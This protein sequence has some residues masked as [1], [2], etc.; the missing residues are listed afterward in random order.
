MSLQCEAF[1]Q[2]LDTVAALDIIGV[3]GLTQLVQAGPWKDVH[4]QRLVMAFSTGLVSAR[5]Q[6]KPAKRDSQEI[7]AFQ[8]WAVQSEADVL[9]THGINFQVKVNTAVQM[10][11]RMGL[12]LPSEDSKAHIMCV[13]LAACPEHLRTQNATS[14]REDYL[15]L[16]GSIRSSFKNTRNP[17]PQGFIVQWPDTPDGLPASQREI[18]FGDQPYVAIC[19]AAEVTGA[20]EYLAMRGNSSKLKQQMQPSAGT[21]GPMNNPMMMMFQQMQQTMQHCMMAAGGSHGG[22]N[23]DDIN[24]S[25][26]QH[27]NRPKQLQQQP[28]QQQ[29]Q[30]PVQGQLALE[31]PPGQLA[32][33]SPGLNR[34]L[35]GSTESVA[36]D[37]FGGSNTPLASPHKSEG[38]LSPDDQARR[39][40]MSLG[41]RAVGETADD[42]DDADEADD[43]DPKKKPAS[44]GN[45][46]KAKAKA[47]AKPLVHTAAAAKKTTVFFKPKIDCEH[48]RSQYLF[49]SGIPKNAGGLPS[50]TFAY[51][52]HGGK[53]GAEKAALKYLSDFKK[54]HTCA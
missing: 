17:G 33:P 45:K 20:R 53:K 29:H 36:S 37:M 14:V 2:K 15:K 5:G 42:A 21:C 12:I 6:P 16:T 49:R 22:S 30:Q 3:D 11:T 4:K 25:F 40:L 34:N 26:N 35:R 24:I 8:N 1:V 32:L 48:S 27:A 23:S 39:F 10:M 18:I 43:A 28:F 46:A 19:T 41:G 50:Q 51:S 54:S 31:A 13:L 9:K 47:K 7:T 52:A 44:K 38:H